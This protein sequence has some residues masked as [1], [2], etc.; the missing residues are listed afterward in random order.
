[1]ENTSFQEHTPV[2]E[3]LHEDF[4]RIGA[5]LQK[6]SEEVR[7]QKISKYPI[8]IAQMQAVDMGRP[9]RAF[10]MYTLNYHYNVSFLEE[11]VQKEIVAMDKVNIFRESWKHP[12]KYACFFL[13]TPLEAGFVYVPYRES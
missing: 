5:Y 6:L 1:M 4:S 12:E 7:M 2:L 10:E 11:F 3:K 13:V 9:I 8:Y